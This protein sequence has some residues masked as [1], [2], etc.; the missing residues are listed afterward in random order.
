LTFC[1]FCIK[2]KEREYN[3]CKKHLLQKE[4]KTK[5]PFRQKGLLDIKE[6]N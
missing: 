3:Q 6:K 4:K 1:F 2:A 5:K